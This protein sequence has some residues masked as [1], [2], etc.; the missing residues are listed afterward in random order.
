MNI[1][2]A[3]GIRSSIFASIISVLSVMNPPGNIYGFVRPTKDASKI[4]YQ[5]KHLNLA[6]ERIS[7]FSAQNFLMDII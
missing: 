7:Q 3:T 5:E 6:S 4:A 1:L 2:V